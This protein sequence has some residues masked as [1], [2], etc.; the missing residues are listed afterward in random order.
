MP[1][2]ASESRSLAAL[3]SGRKRKRRRVS[4]G[5]IERL[6]SE[7]DLVEMVRGY[8]VELKRQGRDLVG[9]CPFHADRRPSL[10]VTPGK[11]LWHCLG[12]CNE[13]GSVIDWVMKARGVGFAQALELLREK[14]PG[15]LDCEGVESGAAMRSALAVEFSA[16]ECA[17]LGQVIDYYRQTLLKTPAALAYL[18]KRGLEDRELIET[19]AIG[20]ADRTLGLRLPSRNL[21]AGAEVRHRL[22]RIGI[23]RESSGHEHF[24]GCLV[25][26]IMDREGRITEI[27][28]RKIGR[29]KRGV[30]P[31]LYLPGPHRG[32]FNVR[33]LNAGQVI[34]CEAIIDALTWWKHGYRNVT[35]SYGA[36]GLGDELIDTLVACG[37]KLVYL[38]QDADQA[39]EKAALAAAEKLAARGIAGL[40]LPLPYSLDVNEFAL[41]YAPARENL[42][43]LLEA[44]RPIGNGNRLALASV[45]PEGSRLAGKTTGRACSGEIPPLAAE[46]QATGKPGASPPVEPCRGNSG[47]LA[48]GEATKVKN[49][50]TTRERREGPRGYVRLR[51]EDLELGREDRVYQLRGL[52]KSL[53]SNALRVTLRVVRDGRLYIDALDLFNARQRLAFAEMAAKELGID[54]G[55]IRS[56]ISDLLLEIENLRERRL[57]RERQAKGERVEL[58]DREHEQALAFLRD[59]KL[60]ERI[61]ADFAYCGLVGEREN[62]LIEYLA[63]TSRLMSDPLALIIQ[64]LTAAGKTT[65][66]NFA[67]AFMPPEAVVKFTSLSGQSLFYMGE[68]DLKHK[69]LAISE[70]KGAERATYA[71]KIMQSEGEL[72]MASTGKNPKSGRFTTHEYKVEGPANIIL[73]TT[74][75]EVDEEFANRCLFLNADE[76]RTQ[77]RAIQEEQRRR[78]TLDWLLIK[79]QRKRIRR[80]HQNAQRLLRPV[81]VVNPYAEQLSFLDTRVRYRRDQPKYLA[82]IRASALLHQYQRPYGVKALPDGK[83]MEYIEVT[84]DD[85]ELANRLFTKIMGSH[86]DELPPQTRRLLELIYRMVQKRCAAEHI[87]QPQCL[88]TR[89]AVREFTGWHDTQLKVHL[90]RLVDLEYLLT[91]Y[92]KNGRRYVYELI[93]QGQGQDGGRFS[94]GLVDVKTLC[95]KAG[96]NHEYG[97]DLS[98]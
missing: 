65:L 40:R 5:E 43:A 36:N 57:E 61:L 10:V 85:I 31:H 76:Q 66:M 50:G 45:P 11:N 77:T 47:V 2:K 97:A 26:P 20:F 30:S 60:V 22:Q 78:E 98:G 80:L 87:E 75:I 94:L 21:A 62:A 84:L 82:L 28:G 79:Q 18:K 6:K 25:F 73:A 88:F 59:R 8:G 86:L 15:L 3:N 51:G 69:I 56:D 90:D 35:A 91:R 74:A 41:R 23:L 96:K 68:S 39:G 93:Y 7:I 13:G 27:Y 70:E 16:D 4:E 72:C 42:Q 24:N 53:M 46:K 32:V 54:P 9:L 38:S 63:M 67:L 49:V 44:A 48:A 52:G 33:G 81:T 29:V 34:L 58:S 55:P 12:A 89:R 1:P 95:K 14:H 37:V 19:F 92:G 71:L 64:S 17:L 83:K